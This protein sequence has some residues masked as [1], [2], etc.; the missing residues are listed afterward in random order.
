MLLASFSIHLFT[1]LTFDVRCFK[2]CCKP[3]SSCNVRASSFC[4]TPLQRMRHQACRDSDSESAAFQFN[5][6]LQKCATVS[7]CSPSSSFCETSVSPSD[8]KP[9]WER[10]WEFGEVRSGLLPPNADRQTDTHTSEAG[11]ARLLPHASMNPESQALNFRP[12]PHAHAVNSD[13]GKTTAETTR[14]PAVR[15]WAALTTVRDAANQSPRAPPPFT[16]DNVSKVAHFL[17]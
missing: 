16:S 11:L 5:F 15:M 6:K 13:Q 9:V 1:F 8:K 7:I 2:T 17:C 14:V 10:R 12:R 3:N 4:T